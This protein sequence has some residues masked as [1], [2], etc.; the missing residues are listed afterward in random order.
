MAKAQARVERWDSRQAGEDY[1]L[2]QCL[3][4]KS[5]LCLL[6]EKALCAHLKLSLQSCAQGLHFGGVL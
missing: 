6:L 1:A 4:T 3:H 5:L 2:G